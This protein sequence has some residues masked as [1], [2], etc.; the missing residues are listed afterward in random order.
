MYCLSHRALT[1]ILTLSF[2]LF[3]STMA[4]SEDTGSIA[5]NLEAEDG[6]PVV[7]ATVTLVELRQQTGVDSK[8]TFRFDDLSPG[9]YFLHVESPRHGD[10]VERLEVTAGA[11]SEIEILMGAHHH[12]DEIVVTGSADLRSQM[13]LAHPVTVLSGELLEL[14]VQPTLGDTLTQEPGINQTWFAP[15]ASR[16]IIR[17]LGGDRV[18]MLQGGLSAGD[19]SSTSPDHA[20]GIDPGT[21][22]KIEVLRGPSTLLYGSTAIGGVV[23]VIDNTIP[24]VQPTAAITG[25]VAARGGTV[26][27]ERYGQLDLTGGLGQWAWHVDAAL[28]ETDDYNIPDEYDP[29]D[30]EELPEDV[31]HEEDFPRG[32]LPNSDLETRSAAA[33]LSYFGSRGFLGVS[34]SGFDTNYGVPGH[35][36]HDH[37]EDG[38]TSQEPGPE[39]EEGQVR[40]DLER[41]RFD[42]NGEI[43]RPFSIFRGLRARVGVVDY[44]HRE[45]E[46]VEIGTRF[47]KETLEGRFEL[48]QRE[49]GRW[50]GSFGLQYLDDDLEAIGE[51]AFL[52]PS[53]TRNLGLFAFEEL[54]AKRLS[55]QF[56]ARIESVDNSVRQGD[57]PDRS[58][59]P[60]SLSVGVVWDLPKEWSLGASLARSQKAP[61]A[62]ELYSDGAH[63][64]T[65]TYEIGDPDLEVETSLGFDISLRRGG[66]PL[67]GE[68]SLFFNRFADFIFQS[69]TGE[70]IEGLTV[71][72]YSQGDAEFQGG[73]LDLE[74]DLWEDSHSHLDLKMMAD[75]VRAE[76]RDTGEPLPLIPPMRLGVGLHFGS[77]RWHAAGEVRWVDEQDRVAENELTTPSYTMV[78]ASV[79]YRIYLKHQ[80]ID[81]ML[82][83]TNLTDELAF[84]A[85]SV[86]KFQRPMPGRDVSLLARVSF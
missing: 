47:L 83:G 51:E 59:S 81:L 69:I 39:Q 70:E 45:L 17:G 68:L 71:L 43:T 61:N 18:R 13:E 33:G 53:A 52:P 73:E 22:Q 48:V 14:R 7:D 23:N 49:R 40:V 65:Q 2:S 36:H 12:S 16:P 85:T 55:W 10:R 54:T 60:F 82:R 32:V 19:V 56:G 72:Q 4:V 9:Q 8:G 5:G 75:Y 41:R 64:A 25:S 38:E 35:E 84:N 37:Q 79:G 80:L 27:D 21:A 34:A 50:S 6:S 26:A 77:L 29:E 78:N 28:R 1:T 46:G 67:H 66:G 24:S 31:A 30:F 74:Y 3:S 11:T 58:F 20:V 15:G 86:Q 42:F 62:S 76:I 57:L 44:E 63:A